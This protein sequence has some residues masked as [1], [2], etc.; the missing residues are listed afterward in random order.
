MNEKRILLQIHVYV[1]FS[2]A[3]DFIFVFPYTVHTA[4]GFEFKVFSGKV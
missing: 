3:F 1:V 4:V 2:Y